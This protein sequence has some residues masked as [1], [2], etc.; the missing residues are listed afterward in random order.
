MNNLILFTSIVVGLITLVVSIQTIFETRN[1]YYT[2]YL[3]R[4]RNEKT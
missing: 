4:K 1:K 2:D 3:K